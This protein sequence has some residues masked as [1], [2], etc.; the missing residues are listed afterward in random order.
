VQTLSKPPGSALGQGL[1]SVA[2]VREIRRAIGKGL[3]TFMFYFLFFLSL[4]YFILET[5]ILIGP[6]GGDDSIIYT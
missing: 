5:A 6:F 2:A 3:K 4:E 1:F